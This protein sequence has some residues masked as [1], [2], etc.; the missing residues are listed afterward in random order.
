[1][2]TQGVGWLVMLGDEIFGAGAGLYLADEIV[3][4]EHA[5]A[6][7]GPAILI[8]ALAGG[9]DILDVNGGDPA[10]I[11]V[12]PAERIGLAAHDPGDV[13]FPFDIGRG[14]Q[15]DFHRRAARTGRHELE[16]VIMPAEA[17]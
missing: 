11:A 4:V 3:P 7:I 14:F 17:I 6:D 12:E 8:E 10:A 15:D 9:R 13:A 2:E 5:M 1:G 16:I